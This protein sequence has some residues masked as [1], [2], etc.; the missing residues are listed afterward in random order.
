MAR[1][2]LP[3][4]TKMVQRVS[5]PK[6]SPR[7]A[8]GRPSP[9]LWRGLRKRMV[10]PGWDR[11]RG[12][13]QLAEQP[14]PDTQESVYAGISRFIRISKNLGKQHFMMLLFIHCPR[15]MGAWR[16]VSWKRAFRPTSGKGGAVQ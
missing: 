3:S 15:D 4:L 16:E 6:C 7:R 10:L 2:T 8:P 13:P 12:T 9:S 5:F 14:P 1:N 11:D